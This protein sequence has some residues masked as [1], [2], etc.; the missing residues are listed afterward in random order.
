ME[1]NVLNIEYIDPAEA[2]FYFGVILFMIVTIVFIMININKIRMK[3]YE[4]RIN[5]PTK[6]QLK[7]KREWK[8]KIK[9]KNKIDPEMFS[10]EPLD[11]EK[12]KNL[13]Y[14]DYIEQ[15]WKELK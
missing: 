6:E 12:T 8:R 1:S 5:K 4:N 3:I 15:Q 11:Y 7:R 2:D 10:N 9:E 14:K 13:K